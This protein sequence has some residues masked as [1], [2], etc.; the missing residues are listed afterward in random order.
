MTE[1]LRYFIEKLHRDD[2][3]QDIMEYAL[4]AGFVAAA[5]V[6]TFPFLSTITEPLQQV[7]IAMAQIIGDA[8]GIQ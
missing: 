6:A 8:A 5:A 2:R 7:L 1:N 3:G 4:L